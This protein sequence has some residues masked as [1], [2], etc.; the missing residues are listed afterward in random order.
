MPPLNSIPCIKKYSCKEAGRVS[1]STASKTVLIGTKSVCVGTRLSSPIVPFTVT[2]D[3]YGVTNTMNIISSFS[4]KSFLDAA[5]GAGVVVAVGQSN[6]LAYS[7]DG[8]KTWSQGTYSG[9]G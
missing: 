8:G 9:Y 7:E 1:I 6:L 2:S 3:D 4:G 5:V